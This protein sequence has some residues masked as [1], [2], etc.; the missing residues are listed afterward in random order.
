[1]AKQALSLEKVEPAS[2]GSHEFTPRC[3]YKQHPIFQPLVWNY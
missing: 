1:M 2:S 3:S